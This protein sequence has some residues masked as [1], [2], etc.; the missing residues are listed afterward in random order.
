MVRRHRE[1]ADDPEVSR[2]G[3]ARLRELVRKA[4]LRDDVRDAV[5]EAFRQLGAD[6]AVAVRSSATAEDTAGAS[7]AGMH[8][9]YAETWSAR[10]R[11]SAVC[12]TAGLRST[13]SV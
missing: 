11:C 9:T 2:E 13:E 6:V 1:R 7:Y 5:R 12:S 10:L 4:G 8:E 3:A